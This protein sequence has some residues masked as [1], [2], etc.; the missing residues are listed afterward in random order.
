MHSKLHRVLQLP[1]SAATFGHVLSVSDVAVDSHS[2]PSFASVHLRHSKTDFFGVG[3]TVF[4]GGVD[5]LVSP[6]KALLAYL[7]LR[8]P[9]PGPLFVFQFRSSL[10]RLD[11]VRAV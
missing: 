8:G 10:S 9:A 6:V 3:T 11:L 4:L 7:A 2:N 1:A 5:G